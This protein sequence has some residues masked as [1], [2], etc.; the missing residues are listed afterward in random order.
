MTDRATGTYTA[1]QLLAL[2]DSHKAMLV[3]LGAYVT[4]SEA[5]PDIRVVEREISRATKI[6]REAG[7]E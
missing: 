3:L 6:R 7:I 2:E 5:L 4:L 1:E